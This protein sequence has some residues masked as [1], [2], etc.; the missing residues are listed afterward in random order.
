MDITSALIVILVS[1]CSALFSEFLSWLLI[2]RT[3]SYKLCKDRLEN[4]QEK[5]D[6]LQ[7][8]VVSVAKR[9]KHEK[10][11]EKLENEL[12][13][14]KQQMSGIRMKSMFFLSGT[15]ITLL[16]IMNS[17]FEGVVVARLPFMPFGLVQGLSHRNLYGTDFYDCSMTFIYVLCSMGIRPT[18]QKLLG[19]QAP[20]GSNGFFPEMP[21]EK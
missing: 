8:K 13:K 1:I 5:L 16:S 11:I 10:S 9:A 3:D 4:I 15:M 7:N 20:K 19:F 6:A 17:I 12:K 21:K 18:V 2:Y 14:T